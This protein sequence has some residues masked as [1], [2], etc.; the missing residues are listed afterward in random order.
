[1]T[2]IR[3]FAAAA[4][5]AVIGLG[6]ASATSAADDVERFFKASASSF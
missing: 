3:A 5:A 6:T 4:L 1:M 2:T